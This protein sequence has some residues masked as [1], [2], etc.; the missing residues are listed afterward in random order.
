MAPSKAEVIASLRAAGARRGADAAERDAKIARQLLG[1]PLPP[2]MRG[3]VEARAEGSGAT[4]PEVAE[5]L[6]MT[7]NAAASLWRRA[8]RRRPA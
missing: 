1:L 3:V 5:T 2:R 8:L 6:G 4:W 7:V